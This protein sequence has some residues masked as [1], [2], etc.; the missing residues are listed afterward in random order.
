[1][2]KFLPMVYVSRWAQDSALK[3]MSKKLMQFLTDIEAK[4]F[5]LHNPIV[6]TSLD[7]LLQSTNY[8]DR[9]SAS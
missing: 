9:L 7:K 3:Q 2:A 6:L 4:L 8:E 1:M 5:D